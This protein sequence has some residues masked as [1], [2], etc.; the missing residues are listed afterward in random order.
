MRKTT[1]VVAM[2]ATVSLLA[3]TGCTQNP[4]QTGSDAATTPAASDAAT[5]AASDAATTPAASDAA[6]PAVS[7]VAAPAGGADASA[8]E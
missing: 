1:K 7:D 6:T 2:I 8:L 5:P 4:A 3:L